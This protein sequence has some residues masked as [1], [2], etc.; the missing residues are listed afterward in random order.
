VKR[1][2]FLTVLIPLLIIGLVFAGAGCPRAQTG[3]TATLDEVASEV[4]ALADAGADN[5]GDISDIKD[6]IDDLQKAIDDLQKAIDDVAMSDLSGYATDAE[7]QSALNN[8]IN[9]LSPDQIAALKTKLGITSSSSSSSTSPT[10]QVTVKMVESQYVV[11]GTLRVVSGLTSSQIPLTVEVANP[12]NAYQYISYSLNL[13]FA[14][15]SS[16]G[17]P[18]V[19]VSGTSFAPWGYSIDYYTTCVPNTTSGDDTRQLLF[20]PT[21]TTRIGVAPGATLQIQNTLTIRQNSGGGGDSP[22]SA[23]WEGTLAGVVISTAPW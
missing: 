1:K 8:F 23:Q 20:T 7:L 5:A 2:L 18:D 4:D 11:N 9:N 17:Y 6:N 22:T 21:S 12:T 13:N 3:N 10:G 15:G 16:A 14:G 19:L